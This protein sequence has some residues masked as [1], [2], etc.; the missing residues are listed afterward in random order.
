[1]NLIWKTIPNSGSIINKCYMCIYF[2]QVLHIY[3]I[4]VR[5]NIKFLYLLVLLLLLYPLEASGA[6]FS[7]AFAMPPTRIERF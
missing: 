6:Y 5:S 4:S 7:L 2:S 3:Y 1:M